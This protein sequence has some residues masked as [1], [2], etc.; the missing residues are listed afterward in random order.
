M[1]GSEMVAPTL[2][3]DFKG[4]CAFVANAEHPE[5]ATRLD[6]VM[7]AAEEAIPGLCRHDP[8]LIF[9]AKEDFA[10]AG[11]DTHHLSFAGV[12]GKDIGLWDLRGK[13]LVLDQDDPRTGRP[14]RIRPSYSEVLSLER[15]TEDSGEVDPDWVQGDGFPEIGARLRIEHGAVHGRQWSAK[16]GLA[17]KDCKPDEDDWI[18]FR[19]VVR[20]QVTAQP[21]SHYLRLLAGEHEWIEFKRSAHVTICNLCPYSA[22][23]PAIA[24]DVLAYYELAPVPLP[25]EKRFVLHP[26]TE[27]AEIQPDS[28]E[29]GGDPSVGATEGGFSAGNDPFG[30]YPVRPGTEACP[31]LQAFT[32]E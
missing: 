27:D 7:V 15:L 10:N 4:L 21:Q 24:E 8:V 19:Q 32:K 14:L 22:G 31:P 11:K 1:E 16:W 13:D 26:F 9:R 17:L 20:W 23:S 18:Y 30:G 5:A 29:S 3:V 25:S 6:V 2:T 28:T 12:D